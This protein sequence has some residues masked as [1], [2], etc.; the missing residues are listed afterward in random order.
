MIVWG[1][2]AGLIGHYF[3][4]GGRYDPITDTWTAT[5]TNNVPDGR[6]RHTAVWTDS[7]IKMMVWEE[8]STLILIRTPAE[9]LRGSR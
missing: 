1:G 3:N 5:S 7:G 6:Y 4:T 9:V 8:D 2:Q